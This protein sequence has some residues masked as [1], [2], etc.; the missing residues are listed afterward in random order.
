MDI[1]LWLHGRLAELATTKRVVH[2]PEGASLG[3][4]IGWLIKEYGAELGREIER[5]D[6]NL[7]T[8]NGNYC[9]LSVDRGQ[10]LKSGDVV[11]FAPIIAGG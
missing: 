8:L 4:L 3:D 7:I 10:R 5:S 6:E 11:A 9:K 1:K 2:L